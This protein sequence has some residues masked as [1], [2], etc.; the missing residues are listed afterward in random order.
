MIFRKVLLLLLPFVFL[1]CYEVKL[2]L[3]TY[4]EDIYIKKFVNEVG[5]YNLEVDVTNA[6]IEEFLKD[7]RLNVVDK[8]GDADAVLEGV[9]T[10]YEVQPIAWD[11]LKNIVTENRIR[12]SVTIRF[13]DKKANK[14]LWEDHT[15]VG[16][17]LMGEATFS[18]VGT[19][20]ETEKDAKVKAAQ[21]LARDIVRRVIEGWPE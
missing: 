11:Y 8:E 5:E 13:W 1:S 6:V 2:E 18:V 16:G 19:N 15:Q 3:P 21:D 10:G 20:P 4:I 14:L 9:I 17:Y 7:G 12:I